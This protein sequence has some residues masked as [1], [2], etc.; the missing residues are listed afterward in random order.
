[1]NMPEI[2]YKIGNWM[3]KQPKKIIVVFGLAILIVIGITDYLTGI[4]LSLLIF[5]LIPVLLVS[6]FVGFRAG[7]FISFLCALTWSSE[8]IIKSQSLMHPLIPYWNIGA[9]FVVFLIISFSIYTIKQSLIREKE[10]AL[11]DDLTGIGNRRF[12]YEFASN[13]IKRAQ[14]YN[15][16]LTLIYLDLNNFKAVNDKFGHHKG[17]EVLK[18]VAKTMKSGMRSIDIIARFG[19]DEF[20]ALLPETGFDGARKVIDRI[21]NDIDTIVGKENPVS[22]SIGAVTLEKPAGS[23]DD[24]IKSAEALMYEEKRSEKKLI[25]HKI[26]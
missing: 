6:W 26:A 17:D 20:V 2:G 18:S 19:G 4:Y 1:M 21:K 14:R 24:L 13:E 25:R 11:I 12:F 8:D 16:Q 22:A 7:I 5:Y 3:A 9:D 10:R 15:H 23:I